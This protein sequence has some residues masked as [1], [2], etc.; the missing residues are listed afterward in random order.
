MVIKK[1]FPPSPPACTGC[2]QLHTGSYA[3]RLH[4]RGI[5]CRIQRIYVRRLAPRLRKHLPVAAPGS[6]VW[7]RPRLRR[8]QPRVRC[9]DLLSDEPAVLAGVLGTVG[10]SAVPSRAQRMNTTPCRL[11]SGPSAT[12]SASPT[13]IFP[14][15]RAPTTAP[16]PRWSARCAAYCGS[17]TSPRPWDQDGDREPIRH[18]AT[19]SVCR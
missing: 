2:G 17:I 14:R 1:H 18:G 6:I 19:L 3:E 12:R 13:A 15:W 7:P 8:A 16:S 9:Q 5:H 10:C 11:L 4:Q